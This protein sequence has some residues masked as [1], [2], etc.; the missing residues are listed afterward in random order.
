MIATVTSA[1]F[2]REK[3]SSCLPGYS[4]ALPP[5]VVSA[6]A[7]LRIAKLAVALSLAGM[8]SRSNSISR[9]IGTG[10][11][12]PTAARMAVDSESKTIKIS[13][14]SRV[15][16]FLTVQLQ[17]MSE[18]SSVDGLGQVH[19]CVNVVSERPSPKLNRDSAVV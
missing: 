12:V 7:S 6:N 10:W 11:D 3:M 13:S 15:P 9:L 19:A 5:A 8:L 17:L 16:V 1:P 14:P 2:P 4:L 18:S